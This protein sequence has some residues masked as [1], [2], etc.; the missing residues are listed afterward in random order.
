MVLDCF[1]DEMDIPFWYCIQLFAD[2][3]PHL[4]H[5]FLNYQKV[6]TSHM[7]ICIPVPVANI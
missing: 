7:K 1:M 5:S 6:I 3:K 4:L 2:H